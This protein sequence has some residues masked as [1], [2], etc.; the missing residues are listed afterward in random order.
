MPLSLTGISVETVPGV[1][2]GVSVNVSVVSPSVSFWPSVDDQVA[3]RLVLI[4]RGGDQ[5][6]VRRRHQDLRAELLLEVLRAAEM[7]EW[8]WLT[9]G[10][11]EL[12]LRRVEAELLQ[13]AD[14][15]V[16]DRV[17]VDR[18][19]QDDPVR[20]L[21]RPGGV[22]GHADVIQV[23]EHLDRFRVPGRSIGRTGGRTAASRALSALR[24]RRRRDVAVEHRP[25]NSSVWIWPAAAL[26]AATCASGYRPF[27]RRCRRRCNPRRWRRIVHDFMR[28]SREHAHGPTL[29]GASYRHAEPDG[30]KF[31]IEA[32]LQS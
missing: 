22:L 24:R 4:P 8:P 18:I 13:S 21:D 7:I 19:E 17:V 20:G 6:P 1:C 14:D 2:P 28:D 32:G 5:L 3:R 31:G 26:A 29:R 11:D 23:V 30:G 15:F 25:L 27:A 9:S 16:F 12:D 10:T